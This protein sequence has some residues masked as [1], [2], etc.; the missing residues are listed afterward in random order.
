MTTNEHHHGSACR[1]VRYMTHP[2]HVGVELHICAN[3]QRVTIGQVTKNYRG[4]SASKNVE[5]SVAVMDALVEDW[6]AWRAENSA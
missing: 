2:E 1:A 4:M 3:K 6:L 5:M